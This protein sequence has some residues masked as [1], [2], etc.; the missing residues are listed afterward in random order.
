MIGPRSIAFSPFQVDR[1]GGDG[2]NLIL[3]GLTIQN[4]QTYDPHVTEAV[5][6]FLLRNR[7]TDFGSDLIARNIQVRH[8][9][10]LAP[11]YFSYIV[12]SLWLYQVML[13][14]IFILASKRT[15]VAL[16][17]CVQKNL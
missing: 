4:A 16:V 5:T 11:S 1:D 12:A 13:I 10:F 9:I 6:N 7:T 8:F 2:F 15:W 3:N 17:Q 14:S